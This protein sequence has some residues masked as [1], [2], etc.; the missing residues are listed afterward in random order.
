MAVTTFEPWT[1]S[2]KSIKFTYQSVSKNYF[3]T[4]IVLF[5]NPNLEISLL[6]SVQAQIN[7]INYIKYSNLLS[8][9]SFFASVEEKEDE[10][11]GGRGKREEVGWE[12]RIGG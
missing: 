5:C 3:N 8:H 1:A 9:K 6:N 7:R 10:E 11:R 4:I 12:G 2:L